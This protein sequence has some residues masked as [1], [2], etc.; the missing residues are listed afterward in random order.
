MNEPRTDVRRPS[1]AA[2][3]GFLVLGVVVRALYWMQAGDLSLVQEPTGDAL[4]HLRFAE[5]LGLSLIHI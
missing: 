1:L 4:T 5:D 3:F 2:L